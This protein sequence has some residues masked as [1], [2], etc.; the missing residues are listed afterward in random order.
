MSQCSNLPLLPVNLDA[1]PEVVL[2]ELLLQL[3]NADRIALLELAR[4]SPALYTSAVMVAIRTASTTWFQLCNDT[5]GRVWCDMGSGAVGHLGYL[6]RRDG[7]PPAVYLVTSKNNFPFTMAAG[8]RSWPPVIGPIAPHRLRNLYL[9][10]GTAALVPL[11]LPFVRHLLCDLIL[12]PTTALH[13][14][15]TICELNGIPRLVSTIGVDIFHDDQE[16]PAGVDLFAQ[17]SALTAASSAQD[18]QLCVQCPLDSVQTSMNGIM[19]FLLTGLPQH[20]LVSLNVSGLDDDDMV[21]PPNVADSVTVPWP[22]TLQSLTLNLGQGGGFGRIVT[23][24]LMNLPPGLTELELSDIE[25]QDAGIRNRFMV[26]LTPALTSLTI[27]LAKGVQVHEGL[28]IIIEALVAKCPTLRKLHI[29]SHFSTV[30]DSDL[31]LLA[32][33]SIPRL[34]NLPIVDLGLE[35][36]GF[37]PSKASADLLVA[38]GTA[39]PCLRVLDLLHSDKICLDQVLLLVRALPHL[40]RL[41]VQARVGMHE[42]AF[43]LQRERPKLALETF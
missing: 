10:K 5:N 11:T 30:H 31:L 28:H 36:W 17:V 8:S 40:I 29:Q 13:L 32:R 16:T 20:S 39:L 34:G 1:L 7:R 42:F 37:S 24:L 15:N 25:V 21:M 9:T 27:S 35:S 19:I 4:A 12:S 43:D 41:K 3:A 33:E 6:E 23:R 14:L 26:A 18:I 38:V 2:N 22:K